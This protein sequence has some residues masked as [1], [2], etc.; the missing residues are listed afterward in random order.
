MVIKLNAEANAEVLIRIHP[1]AFQTAKITFGLES[2]ILF[3]ECLE[4]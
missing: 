2:P 4:Y 3:L 1:N